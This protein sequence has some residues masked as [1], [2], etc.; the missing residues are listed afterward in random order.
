MIPAPPALRRADATLMHAEAAEAGAAVD[1]FLSANRVALTRIGS[2]LRNLRPA[3][4]VTVA[5]G[6]SDHAATYGKYLFET[7]LGVPT[8][9]AAPSIASIYAAPVS[10]GVKLCV[11]ISQSGRSPDLLAAVEAQARSGALVVALVNDEASPLAALADE[12]LPLKAGP[13]RSV[14]ATKSCITALAGLAALAAAWAEDE[15]LATAVET[16]PTA[17]PLACALDWQP[18]IDALVP[19]RNLFVI[20]RGYGYGI[21]Q[22]AALK[23]KETCALHAEAFSAAEVR[24]GPMTIVGEGFPILAFATADAAGDAVRE[25]ATAFADRG[26]TLCL[27][28]ARGGN[29]LARLPATAA[30]PAIE[31]ILMLQSFYRMAASLSI[32]R[33]LDPDAPP[34]LAK[35]TRTL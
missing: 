6:S 28:D 17:L 13:E 9:T 12:V 5:R 2:R 15:A 27:A 35:V 20:G 18:A 24:H 7:L 32:A 8:A 33:G 3:V 23:L 30:H 26:A 22:E 34:H 25:I 29:R 11:A 31:P 1:R 14:A 21:A 16:L 10:D 19:A 4:V